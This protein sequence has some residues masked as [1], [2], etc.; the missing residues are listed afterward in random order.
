MSD[1]NVELVRRAIAAAFRRPAPDRETA[2]QLYHREHELHSLVEEMEGGHARGA[3]GARDF[4]QRWDETGDWSLRDL[5]QRG[6][7]CCRDSGSRG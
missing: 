3:K 5:Q 4:L 7:R 1:G 2:N 6:T